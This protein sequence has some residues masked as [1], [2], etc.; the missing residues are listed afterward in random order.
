MATAKGGAGGSG[1][2]FVAALALVICLMVEFF[3]WVLGA[4]VL[5]GVVFAVRRLAPRIRGR[6]DDAAERRAELARRADEQHRWIIH[7]DDRGVYGPD[8]ADAMRKVSPPPPAAAFLDEPPPDFPEVASVVHSW[9]ELTELLEKKPPCWRWAAFASVL[10]QRRAPLQDRLRDSA[11]GFTKPTGE[12]LITGWEVGG[13]I[14][15]L[16]D[17]FILLIDG[18]ES[19]MR[20]PA[21]TNMFG[22]PGD[23]GTA[24]ADGI[25]HTAHRLMDYHDRFLALSERCREA[26]AASRYIELLKDC[27]RLTDAPLRGF[28]RFIDDFVA[29]V[30]EM[31]VLLRYATGTVE[32]EPIVLHID[33]D[34]APLRRIVKQINKIPNN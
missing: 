12:R 11:L 21:F 27:A 33:S 16:L 2:A 8:G 24:D 1:V 3:W 5:V 23:E 19:F 15:E 31:P 4:A 9:F 34:D 20:T 32:V 13:F 29:R 18:V 25:V 6:L 14:A 22:A 17:D 26:H 28:Q 10:V 7:G 30:E